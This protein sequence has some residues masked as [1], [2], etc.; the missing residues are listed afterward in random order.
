MGSTKLL[1]RPI[2]RK[3]PWLEPCCHIVRALS[4]RSEGVYM[5]SA[6]YLLQGHQSAWL[7]MREDLSGIWRLEASMRSN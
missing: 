1:S 6:E 7:A 3:A 5:R 2:S 4:E